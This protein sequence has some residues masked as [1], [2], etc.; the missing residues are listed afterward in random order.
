M[1][2]TKYEMQNISSPLKQHQA[3]QKL[4]RKISHQIHDIKKIQH[5]FSNRIH[6]KNQI[7][8]NELVYE[9]HTTGWAIPSGNF[10]PA[11][12][13]ANLLAHVGPRT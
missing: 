2:N 8:S 1:Q 5:E 11:N 10:V 7:K 9:T 3:S 13:A 12:L 4:H 6:N